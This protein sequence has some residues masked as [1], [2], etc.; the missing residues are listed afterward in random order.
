MYCLCR[1]QPQKQFLTKQTNMIKLLFV[2]ED[3]EGAYVTRG[4][5]ELSGGYDIVLGRKG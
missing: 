2:E 5:R 3:E 1:H 4:G